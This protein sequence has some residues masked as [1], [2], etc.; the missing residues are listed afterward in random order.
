MEKEN[1]KINMTD[2]VN[3]AIIEVIT[4]KYKK[5]CPEAH[6]LVQDL[7]YTIEK[8]DGAFCIR[9]TETHKYITCLFTWNSRPYVCLLD[10]KQYNL[11]K[12]NFVKFLN[13]PYNSY[14]RTEYGYRRF[15]RS[16]SD[17]VEKYEKLKMAK[18]NLEYHNEAILEENKKLQ[19]L[20]EKHKKQIEYHTVSI[21]KYNEQIANLR[22]EYGLTK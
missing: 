8:I 5:D 21:E 1:I 16:H 15:S 19:E 6:K 4:H 18:H 3:Y 17:A 14:L 9:N 13:T 7:G 12:I 11:Y 2:K 20:L 22:K 10:K